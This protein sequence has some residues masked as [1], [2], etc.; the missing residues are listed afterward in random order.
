[1]RIKAPSNQILNK[2]EISKRR[3]AISGTRPTK[4]ERPK[5]NLVHRT[6]TIGLTG[7]TG[8]KPSSNMLK[9]GK[10]SRKNR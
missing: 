1:M 8:V 7:A 4:F 3:T 5:T 9:K 6:E 2:V 10:G